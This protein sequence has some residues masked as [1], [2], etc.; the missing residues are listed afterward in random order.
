MGQRAMSEPVIRSLVARRI[1]DSRG[2]PTVEAEVGLSDGVVGRGIAPAGASRGSREAID[3]RD[4]G[5]RLGGLD[6]QKALAGIRAEIAP[7]LFDLDPFDQA[8]V[9]AKLVAIDGTPNKARLG[10]NAL[11]AVSL[12]VLHA[13][14]ASRGLP[15]WR[16]CLGD[17]PA[18]VPLP[19][20][21]IFGGGAHAG[22]RTDV[23]DFMVVAPRAKTFAEALEVTAGV[24]HAAGAIMAERGLLQGVADEGGWWPAF[25]TNEQA[26]DTLML[27]IDRAGRAPGN[28]VAISL[29]VAAS[30]F[31]HDGLYRLGLE[32]RELDRD[33]LAEM[34]LDGY[35]W[36]GSVYRSLSQV[37]KA[38][39]GTN[40]NGH[41][42]FGLKAVRDRASNTKSSA[43]PK[44]NSLLDIGMSP[45]HAAFAPA[46]P[47][48]STH[49]ATKESASARANESARR[50]TGEGG[51]KAHRIGSR[52]GPA[53]RPQRGPATSSSRS[54]GRDARSDRRGAAVGERVE[55]EVTHRLG[56]G[57]TSTRA[58]CD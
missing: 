52:K 49:L 29:D 46:T 55:A 36:N 20:I 38:I 33:G 31:G 6:V 14:A 28:E 42:F 21:Q 39:T 4:G 1:W 51:P 35:A 41:R 3:K 9:D 50:P 17:A 58:R 16:Y 40:W 18:I 53:F 19:E 30:E 25:S 56:R 34:L 47:D 37:A 43:T 8:G 48:R 5:E 10:G 7:A 12:G 22:R 24:Y 27:A 2:R 54:G 26:L 23:Q 11:T 15:L 57:A 45:T 32:K 13:A 44:P